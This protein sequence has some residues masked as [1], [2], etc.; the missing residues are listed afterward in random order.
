[1][2]LEECSHSTVITDL[3][4]VCGI[5]FRQMEDKAKPT[6]ASVSMIHSVPDLKCSIK[7]AKAISKTEENRLL[8]QRK[9]HLL[10]DLDQTLIHTTNMDVPLFV[11][12]TQKNPEALPLKRNRENEFL[13]SFCSRTYFIS[14]FKEVP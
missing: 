1:M 9:L 3:C 12:V 8:K 2:T 14:V 10:V 11:N 13:L 7:E 4:A 5:D 6:G